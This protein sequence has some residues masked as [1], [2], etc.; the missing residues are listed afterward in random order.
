MM[1]TEILKIDASRAEL[2]TK[3]KCANLNDPNCIFF[4]MKILK[5][6]QKLLSTV[7]KRNCYVLGARCKVVGGVPNFT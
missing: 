7:K 3:N 4:F 2:F 1:G 6:N 5:R